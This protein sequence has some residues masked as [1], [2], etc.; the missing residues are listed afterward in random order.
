MKKHDITS[1]NIKLIA[2]G[3][4]SDDWFDLYIELSGHKEYLMRHR[5]NGR[6][7]DLLKDGKCITDMQRESQKL[8]ASL[9]AEGR[10]Y[11]HGRPG[12]ER[13]SDRGVSSKF[14]NT[15][16][17]LVNVASDYIRYEAA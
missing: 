11:N 9:T 1:R 7:F 3:R 17:H 15:I 16:S 12:R 10:R 4:K 14:E 5:R 2:D 13:R 6:L 8:Y